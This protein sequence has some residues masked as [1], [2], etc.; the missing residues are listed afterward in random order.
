VAVAGALVVA[1]SVLWGLSSNEPEPTWEVQRLER[2]DPDDRAELWP[3]F[4]Q[5]GQSYT[6]V[7]QGGDRPTL[8]RTAFAD[9]RSEPLAA[10]ETSAP[11]VAPIGNA[12]AYY[13]RR[14]LRVHDGETRVLAEDCGDPTWSPDARKL[15]CTR[16][17]VQDPHF[18]GGLR[19]AQSVDVVSG[20]STSLLDDHEVLQPDW[21]PD[22]RRL[23]FWS[24]G[25]SCLIA[26]LPSD[27]PP[28]TLFTGWGC[29][30]GEGGRTILYVRGDA[31]SAEVYRRTFDPDSGAVGEELQLTRGMSGQI[32][33]IDASGD[34][35]LI[36]L[37]R[38]Q[39]NLYRLPFDPDL[40]EP[41][42]PL[43][44]VGRK[45]LELEWVSASPDGQNVAFASQRGGAETL[46][47]SDAALTAPRQVGEPGF[48]MR[49]PT[50]SP[51]GSALAYHTSIDGAARIVTV[52]L[53]SGATV[54]ETC[55]DEAMLVP[56]WLPDDRILA[57]PTGGS[58]P[59]FIRGE[60]PAW[61]AEAAFAPWWT[62]HDARADTWTWAGPE[63]GGT[64]NANTGE[65]TMAPEL[66]RPVFLPD[67]RVL[68]VQRPADLALF[69][70]TTQALKTVLSV[71]P[72][73]F[74]QGRPLAVVEDGNALILSL[75]SLEGEIWLLEGG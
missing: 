3:R 23:L 71:R 24:P 45:G 62:V 50:W 41:R 33:S 56:I 2:I 53:A 40:G 25:R 39:T 4:S 51:D 61:M 19:G 70:P 34:D 48:S 16:Y 27:E 59:R 66:D 42:G 49:A 55:D 17:L 46:F 60:A 52:D 5:D 15:I 30:W 18:L 11:V 43:V 54:C 69:D 7:Q 67:G 36:A 63:G 64:V 68:G 22:G 1:G 13:T 44:S 31:R 73:G 20:V 28:K 14:E 32:W 57:Y 38:P 10:Q 12:V 26:D 21:S 74:T 65:H 9:A 35:V 6:S 29:V 58:Q 8:L 72:K 47:V 37:M 75:E